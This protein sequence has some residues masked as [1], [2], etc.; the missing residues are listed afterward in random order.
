[1]AANVF[2]EEL[3]PCGYDPLTGFYRDGCCNV[4]GDDVGV[5]AVCAQM[6]DE[7]LAF[8][9]AQGNDLVT[10]QPAVGFAGLVAGDRWCLCAPRWQE[11]YDAGVAPPVYLAATHIH[12]LEWCSLEALREHALDGPISGR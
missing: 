2:G 1:M 11:A 3:E 9:V 12:A 6:T 7:F 10:P 5:H 8:S 4:G